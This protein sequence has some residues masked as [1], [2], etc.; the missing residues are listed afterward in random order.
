MRRVTAEA[1]ALLRSAAATSSDRNSTRAGAA[2]SRAA[3]R[4]ICATLLSLSPSSPAPSRNRR[5]IEPTPFA[6]KFIAAAMLRDIGWA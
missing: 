3:L 2:A 4:A 5:Q 1:D 6:G